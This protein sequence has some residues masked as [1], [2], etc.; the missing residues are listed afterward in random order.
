MCLNI[1]KVVHPND[2]KG[3]RADF[4][5]PSF[6]PMRTNSMSDTPSLDFKE[7]TKTLNFEGILGEDYQNADQIDSY[8]SNSDER[9]YKVVS[10][11]ADEDDEDIVIDLAQDS[12]DTSS[13]QSMQQIKCG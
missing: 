10:H 7:T 4:H 9:T 3:K 12:F 1:Q 5:M 13:F 6:S 8:N 2:L 11:Y